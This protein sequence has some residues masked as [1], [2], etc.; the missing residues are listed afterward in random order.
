MWDSSL[1]VQLDDY[2]NQL[3]KGKKVLDSVIAVRESEIEIIYWVIN[4]KD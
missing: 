2:K 4:K 1:F 3:T